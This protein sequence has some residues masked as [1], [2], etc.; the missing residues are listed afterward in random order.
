[1]LSISSTVISKGRQQ[2]GDEGSGL[3]GLMPLS[4]AASTSPLVTM[5]RGPLGLICRACSLYWR[6]SD[7]AAGP[8]RRFTSYVSPPPEA[9]LSFGPAADLKC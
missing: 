4:M 1:M 3:L 8:M 6:S 2:T 5:L 7:A 9:S